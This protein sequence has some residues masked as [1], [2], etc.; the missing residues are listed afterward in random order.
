MIN[1]ALDTSG[2]GKNRS[3]NHASYKALKRLITAD[4]IKIYIPYVV[5]REIETQQLAYYLTD[6][7]NL[8]ESLK[9]FSKIPKSPEVSAIISSLQEQIQSSEVKILED[10]S[11]FSTSW[12]NGLNAEPGWRLAWVALLNSLLSNFQPPC[13][14]K[15]RPVYGSSA[16]NAPCTFGI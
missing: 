1:I 13:I 16:I 10:A 7:K 6:Y 3:Q 9:K 4:Q 2:I 8:N 11:N 12:I 14:A 15:T 5:K